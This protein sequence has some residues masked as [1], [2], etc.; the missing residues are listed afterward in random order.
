MDE[1]PDLDDLPVELVAGDERGIDG[2]RSPVVPATDVQIGA[3]DPR[4]QHADHDFVGRRGGV[5]TIHE[6]E[7]GCAFGFEQ[8]LHVSITSHSTM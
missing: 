8:C 2:G 1:R 4:A 5:R 7:P 3:A 6:L